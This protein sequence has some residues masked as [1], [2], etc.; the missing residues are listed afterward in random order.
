MQSKER[1]SEDGS[2]E[3]YCSKCQDWWPADREFF[4]TTGSK[5]KLHSWCKACYNDWRNAR[6]RKIKEVSHEN[7]GS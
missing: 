5:K 1:V 2:L 6:R 4:Y 7:A 3:R